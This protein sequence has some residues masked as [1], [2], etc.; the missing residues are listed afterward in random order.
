MISSHRGVVCVLTLGTWLVV[1]AAGSPGDTTADAVLG[2]P[3]FVSLMG[4]EPA[5]LPTAANF[6]LSNAAH[7]AIAPTGRF[8]VSDPENHRILSWPSAAALSTQQ[9]A[10]MVFGQPDFTSGSPNNGDLSPSSLF[11]PQGLFVEPAGHLW[12]TDAF[13][14]R[15]LRFNDP[16]TDPTPTTADLVIG[17]Y[18]L[19]HNQE[20]LGLGG[21]GPAVALPDSLQFPGRVLV[22]GSDL[23]IADSG[24]SRVLHY[25]Y[26][27]ANKPFADRVWGQ[28]GDLTRRAKNNDGAGNNNPCCASA[29]NLYNP[30]GI[31]LDAAGRLY[32]ADWNNHRVLRYDN[33]LLS[34]TTADAV[35][36][37][38]DFVSN[39][40][41]NGGLVG[42]LQ[43][44]IDL[45]FDPAGRL[46]LADS[47]NHR[48]LVYSNPLASSL[49]DAV[50]GQLDRLN[51]EDANHGLGFFAT[52][53]D[54]LSGPTGVAVDGSENVYVVDTN[55]N[56]LLRYD[57]PLRRPGDMNCD[58]IVDAL[59]RPAFVQ[60]LLDPAGYVAQHLGCDVANGDLNGDGR[61]DGLDVKPFMAHLFGG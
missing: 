41:D 35:F 25:S 40:I 30:I 36:G 9:S 28:Y 4:N 31:T 43:R 22:R 60:A 20:N 56:R 12:V 33:P 42:G 15:V 6:L 13:N 50:F 55:N 19:Y 34:D 51:T 3:D 1:A 52:D 44:P 18:D 5:G 8:Y 61:V 32:V 49:P 17:Q 39:A 46:F 7:A 59:D 27:T 24:N 23:F 21:T 29:D 37:Q 2:Q 48:V 47:G 45:V 54:G 53:A 38:P 10:D 16:A 14:H 57:G 58:G 26:P 11:L